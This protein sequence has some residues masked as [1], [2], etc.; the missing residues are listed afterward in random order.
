[1]QCPVRRVYWLIHLT[2]EKFEQEPWFVHTEE[3]TEVC[4]TGKQTLRKNRDACTPSVPYIDTKTGT[5]SGMKPLQLQY[6]QHNQSRV[7]MVSFRYGIEIEAVPGKVW[8]VLTGFSRY[9]H[10]NP[11][12]RKV[13]GK[14]VTGAP[15]EI[16]VSLS[17]LLP[18]GLSAH[19]DTVVPEERIGWRGELP[20]GLLVAHHWFELQ[21]TEGKKTLLLHAEDFSGP[22]ATPLLALLSGAFRNGYEAMNLA[23]K[24][25]AEKL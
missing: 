7:I 15:I 21:Q 12:I 23:L 18:L 20:F 13:S 14:P 11:F 19:M 10:W 9:Q 25:E 6:R 16:Q 5:F 2:V 1:M 22:L 3:N 24:Q 4:R 17:G 8:E